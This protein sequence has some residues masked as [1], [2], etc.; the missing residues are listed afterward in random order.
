MWAMGRSMH[1]NTRRKHKTEDGISRKTDLS[2]ID[3]MKVEMD[4]DTWSEYPKPARMDSQGG[5]PK[6]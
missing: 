6:R 5:D 3:L 4:Q 2:Y 1:G